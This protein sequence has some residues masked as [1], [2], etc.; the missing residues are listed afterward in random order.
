MSCHFLENRR[1]DRRCSL[2]GEG[3]G[4]FSSFEHHILQVSTSPRWL[5]LSVVQWSL[6]I[7]WI[8]LWGIP[9]P[10]L[11]M[12]QGSYGFT[13]WASSSLCQMLRP[14]CGEKEQLFTPDPALVIWAGS[15]ERWIHVVTCACF[16]GNASQG[17]GQGYQ[18]QWAHVVRKENLLSGGSKNL[19]SLY[20][21]FHPWVCL[22]NSVISIN[23]CPRQDYVAR[24]HVAKTT[25]FI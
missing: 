1:T 3:W 7:V 9:L 24:W 2:P 17:L 16:Y 23:F 4:P 25:C 5:G 20:S 6:I 12:D 22:T 14:L 18:I 8:Q 15:V 21:H 11:S 13:N 10:G 19:F